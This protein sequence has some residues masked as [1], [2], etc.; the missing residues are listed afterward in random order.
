MALVEVEWVG[1]KQNI[2]A[3]Y[4]CNGPVNIFSPELIKQIG[5]TLH[6]LKT[7]TRCKGV[8]MLSKFGNTK[9]N[10]FSAGFDLSL[11]A[12]VL[13]P[14]WMERVHPNWFNPLRMTAIYRES[15]WKFGFKVFWKCT[16][17]E[18]RL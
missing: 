5:D 17:L 11:F 3:V 18:S 13:S 14:L 2:A 6:G 12:K 7:D 15:T 9:R 10:V 4:L 16:A 8:I 1:K